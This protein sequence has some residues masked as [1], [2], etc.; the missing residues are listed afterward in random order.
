MP[1]RDIATVVAAMDAALVRIPPDR[2][3]QRVFLDTYR[4]TTIAVGKAIRDGRFEDPEWVERWDV[5][6]ADL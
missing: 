2:V 5:A 1:T 4:R 6:F 3:G